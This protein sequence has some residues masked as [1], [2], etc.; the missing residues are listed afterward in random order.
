MGLDTPSSVKVPANHSS[1]ISLREV[2]VSS[3]TAA[4]ASSALS[5]SSVAVAATEPGTTES[6][7]PAGALPIEVKCA[8][9]PPPNCDASKSL[10]SPPM[11]NVT[12]TPET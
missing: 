1:C 10:T 7:T 4:A 5:K 6:D 12:S 2:E 9:R 8:V 11:M 3:S